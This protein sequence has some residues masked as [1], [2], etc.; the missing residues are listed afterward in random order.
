M[1]RRRFLGSAA[2]NVALARGRRFAGA[3]APGLGLGLVELGVELLERVGLVGESGTG[4]DVR[5]NG[6]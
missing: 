4:V 2:T 1:G 6:C 5:G 3:A